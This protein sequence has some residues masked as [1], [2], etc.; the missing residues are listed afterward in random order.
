[1]LAR[2]IA[3]CLV[4]AGALGVPLAGQERESAPA[5]LRGMGLVEAPG[6]V[7]VF[8]VPQA[9]ERAM[10][11]RRSLE[12]AQA[13]YRQQLD[14]DVP[15]VLAVV[16]AG[17]EQRLVDLV[18]TREAPTR[19][20]PRL[21][22]IRDRIEDARPAAGADAEHA[23]G[24]VL[25][26]EQILFHDLGHAY[27]DA[28]PLRTG[29]K[30]ADEFVA[31]VFEVAY[32]VAKRPDMSY[33]LQERRSG[34]PPSVPGYS[35]LADL[36]YLD[37]RGESITRANYFWFMWHLS[38]LADALTADKPLRESVERLTKAFP[39]AK[40]ETP[41]TMVKRLERA[42][43][44]FERAAGAL[45]GPSKLPRVE[46]S[47]CPGMSE[48]RGMSY[49]VIRNEMDGALGVT[50]PEGH[51][52]TVPRHSWRTYNVRSGR[53]VRLPGG[54]CLIAGDEPA[55]AIVDRP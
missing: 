21:I 47:A 9:R 13:W 29:S 39:D 22:A 38:R 26:G 48:G 3:V 8:F 6:R 40:R 55:L 36:D 1:M 10:R 7:P 24:G 32:L 5:R 51:T 54:E 16:D 44:G 31:C 17:A 53:W 50:F 52:L 14:V 37:G 49:L 30:S 45:T 33:L 34:Q 15:L 42:L 2:I 20:R 12:G 11:L 23:A 28:L 27:A 46:R 18:S 35:T 19:E 4:G 43:P 25:Q 41:E